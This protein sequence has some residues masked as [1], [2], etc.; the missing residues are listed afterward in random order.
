MRESVAVDIARNEQR[1]V[2]RKRRRE[3]M[4]AVP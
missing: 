1:H 4:T 3:K 2:Q